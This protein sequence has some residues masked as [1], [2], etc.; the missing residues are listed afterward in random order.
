MSGNGRHTNYL[1]WWRVDGL[2]HCC[3]HIIVLKIP[4]SLKITPHRYTLDTRPCN[5]TLVGCMQNPQPVGKANWR[6]DPLIGTVSSL[7]FQRWV[8]MIDVILFMMTLYD[9]KSKSDI[10]IHQ[11]M[12]L[13]YRYT[14]YTDILIYVYVYILMCIVQGILNEDFDQV[15]RTWISEVKQLTS[16]ARSVPWRARHGEGIFLTEITRYWV[17]TYVEIRDRPRWLIYIYIYILLICIYIYTH[18]HTHMHIY[19]YRLLHFT[20]LM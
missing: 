11:Y 18:A 15:P 7:D 3:T 14:G 6:E 19:T 10:S 2:W 5:A 16:P 4:L 20:N 12:I 17:S 1:C 9:S 13:I 8:N